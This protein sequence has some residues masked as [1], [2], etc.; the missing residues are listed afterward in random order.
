MGLRGPKPATADE[1]LAKIEAKT[2]KNPVSGCWLWQGRR[3]PSGYGFISWQGDGNYYIHRFSYEYHNPG[4]IALVV[5]HSCDTT[6]CWNPDHLKNG[7]HGDNV[8]DKVSKDR[9]MY[10]EKHYNAKLTSVDVIEIRQSGL[11]PV[12]L[13]TKYNVSRGTIHFILNN[14]NWK[15]V[16]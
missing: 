5:R 15:H 12:E 11:T 10:G 8:D 2:I 9:H 7:T 13:S 16:S 4:K 6:N 3:L 14:I 1:V